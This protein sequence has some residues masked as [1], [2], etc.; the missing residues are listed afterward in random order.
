M[1]QDLNLISLLTESLF[2][3][4]PTI[5]KATW[6]L[7]ALGLLILLGK[8]AWE[9]YQRYRLS[10]AGMPEIDSMN[11]KTFENYLASL[12]KKMCYSV[13]Q[14]GS[15]AGDYGAD[16]IISKDGQTIAVQAKRHRAVIEVD[17]VR[18]ALGSI[19]MYQCSGAMVVTNSYFTKQA[20]KLAKA[21]NIEL[22]DGKVLAGKILEFSKPKS[23]S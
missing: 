13:K 7:W 14:V 12:F 4:L 20:R 3:S 23:F 19:K 10:K 5:I 6:P 17:A 21:N 22:W 18:E 2:A 11:G 15:F 1:A 16:L 9:L 8:L